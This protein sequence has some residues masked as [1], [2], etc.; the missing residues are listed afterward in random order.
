MASTL[1]S[2]AWQSA[3]ESHLS[4]LKERDRQ[5]FIGKTSLEEFLEAFNVLIK[6]DRWHDPAYH[7]VFSAINKS[8]RPLKRFGSS[9]DVI[10]QISPMIVSPIWAPLKMIVQVCPFHIS[11]HV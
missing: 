6:K 2:P 4:R 10:A 7:G 1:P 9:I 5:T 11:R 3:V 8:L